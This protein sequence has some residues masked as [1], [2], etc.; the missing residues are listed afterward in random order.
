MA[1]LPQKVEGLGGANIANA[2]VSW[3]LVKSSTIRLGELGNSRP[4]QKA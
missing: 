1:G 3:R 4:S 2:R